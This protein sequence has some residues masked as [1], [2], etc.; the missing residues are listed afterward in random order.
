MYKAHKNRCYKSYQ[1]K[2]CKWFSKARYLRYDKAGESRG[3]TDSF[4]RPEALHPMPRQ[5]GSADD[6]RKWC[7][8]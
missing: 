4:L 6:R 5:A 1:R 7:Q 3:I 2:C 8:L